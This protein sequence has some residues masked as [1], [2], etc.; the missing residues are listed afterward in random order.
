MFESEREFLEKRRLIGIM[1]A[2]NGILIGLIVITPV[3]GYV[4]PYCAVILEIV[5]SIIFLIGEKLF[6][7]AKWF[8]DPLSSHSIHSLLLE[9]ALVYQMVYI[10]W[11]HASLASTWVATI[12]F[13]GS[14]W[15]SFCI[16]ICL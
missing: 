14:S 13:T 16:I 8:T 5:G 1:Y 10:R 6:Q 2:V 11:W 3:A 9:G 15:Y 12:G 7:R 4:G